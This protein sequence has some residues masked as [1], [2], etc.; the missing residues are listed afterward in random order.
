MAVYNPKDET[1]MMQM[2]N[3]LHKAKECGFLVELK[4]YHPVATDKQ[5]AYLHFMISYWAMRNG[6]TFYSTLRNIQRH[7]C[8]VY[9]VTSRKDKKGNSVYKSLS[10][11]N[12]AE[13]SSVIRNFLD[14]ASV[15]GT[16][17]PEPDDNVS[18]EYCKRAIES[19]AA[20]WV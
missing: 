20:G 6:E 19:S 3:F 16:M 5:Q 8:P 10:E 11:L 12:T 17:I 15:N 4:K 14:Y 1:E 9:F 13:A 7:V 2:Y 18:I